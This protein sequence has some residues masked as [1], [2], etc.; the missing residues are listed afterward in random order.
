[1]DEATDWI[2]DQAKADKPFLAFSGSRPVACLR[3]QTGPWVQQ[4]LD[5]N[6]EKSFYYAA[7][8][9]MDEAIGVLNKSLEKAGIAENTLIIFCSDGAPTEKT[10]PHAALTDAQG[11]ENTA[12]DE[13]PVRVPAFV[14]ARDDHRIST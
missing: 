3:K 5:L 9:E 4:Y 14:L 1:M 13:P 12:A 8:T 7:L 6:R 11:R 2:E 10:N